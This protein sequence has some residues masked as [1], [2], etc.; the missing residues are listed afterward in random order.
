[1]AAVTEPATASGALAEGGSGDS[2]LHAELF[3]AAERGDVE[4]LRW[5]LVA[6]KSAAAAAR[7]T[8]TD[9]HGNSHVQTPLLAACAA[10]QAGAAKLL[11]AAR[12]ELR[13]GLG[14]EGAARLAELEAGCHD[15]ALHAAARA[16]QL[17]VVEFL[18]SPQ[19]GIRRDEAPLDAQ[20]NDGSTAFSL[21]VR[22]GHERVARLLHSRG[23]DLEKVTHRGASPFLIACQEGHAEL[24]E[25]LATECAV[26]TERAADGGFDGFYM[27]CQNGHTPVVRTLVKLGLHRTADRTE[28]TFGTRYEILTI[29]WQIWGIFCGILA[30]LRIFSAVPSTS[31]PRTDTLRCSSV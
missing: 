13:R 4:T 7:R 27:A 18:L 17:E 22:H 16:G 19:G 23:V 26:D 1:M 15:T 29:F 9:A 28:N 12:E 25:W 24:A 2:A 10:G 6:E 5:M 11:V 8:W 31:A 21:A 20:S 3:A 14:A 30:H